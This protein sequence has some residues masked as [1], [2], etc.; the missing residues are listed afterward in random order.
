MIKPRPLQA[1]IRCGLIRNLLHASAVGTM[2]RAVATSAVIGP[3][4]WNGIGAISVLRE[5]HA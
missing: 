2:R 1:L 4:Y 5:Y 3:R